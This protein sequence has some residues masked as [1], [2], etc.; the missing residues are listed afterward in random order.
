MT[1]PAMR[2]KRERKERVNEDKQTETRSERKT[3]LRGSKEVGERV[4]QKESSN[5]SVRRGE[6]KWE[7]SKTGGLIARD[8]TG[9]TPFPQIL[10]FSLTLLT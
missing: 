4:A 8:P 1:R 9:A 5:Q 2:L 7:A 3:G 6:K 10:H